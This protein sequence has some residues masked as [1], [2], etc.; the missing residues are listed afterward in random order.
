MNRSEIISELET[1]SPMTYKGTR[2]QK[3]AARRRQ[4][5]LETLLDEID[6]GQSIP[7]PLVPTLRK[8]Y[9]ELRGQLYEAAAA[10]NAASAGRINREMQRIERELDKPRGGLR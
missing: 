3:S 8:Q 7:P 6:A 1:I 4:A 9:T 2:A 5:E 10:G